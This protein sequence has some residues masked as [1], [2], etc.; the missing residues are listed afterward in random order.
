M[1][2]SS[3]LLIGAVTVMGP[4]GGASFSSAAEFVQETEKEF[5]IRSKGGLSITNP[6]GDITLK[7]WAQDKIRVHLRKLIEAKDSAEADKKFETL[8]YRYVNGEQ[9][10]EISTQYGSSLAIEDPNKKRKGSARI[11]LTIFA[12]SKMVAKLWGIEGSLEIKNWNSDVHIRLKTGHIVA[13]N[14]NASQFASVCPQCQIILRNI[15]GSLRCVTE[16]G[17]VSVEKVNG[18]NIFIETDSGAISLNEA[19][20]NQTVLSRAGEIQGLHLDG[21]ISFRSTQSNVTLNDVSGSVSGVSGSGNIS[22]RIS[23]WNSEEQSSLETQT[24]RIQVALPKAFS[25]DIDFSTEK[26]ILTSSFPIDATAVGEIALVA[27]GKSARGRIKDGGGLFKLASKSGDLVV[28][29]EEF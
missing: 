14:I 10:V 16:K 26:G 20:G 8:T 19:V 15:R 22:I 11:S 21:D 2:L 13:E 4:L 7:G 27:G 17:S 6:I 5:P 18:E 28:I 24:G 12:P 9:G 3:L 23:K 29:K 25:A 1:R